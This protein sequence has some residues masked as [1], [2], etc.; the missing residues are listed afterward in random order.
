MEIV[1]KNDR[2]S[3]HSYIEIYPEIRILIMVNKYV[4]ELAKGSMNQN[5]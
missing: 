3:A 2:T 5:I 1:K 4:Q